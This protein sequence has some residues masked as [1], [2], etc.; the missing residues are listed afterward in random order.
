MRSVFFCQLMALSVFFCL[1]PLEAQNYDYQSNSTSGFQSDLLAHFYQQE[2]EGGEE[3]ESYSSASSADSC[4]TSGY[5]YDNVC[6]S[7]ECNNTGYHKTSNVEEID[8]EYKADDCSR[9]AKKKNAEKLFDDLNI[10]E[11]SLSDMCAGECPEGETCDPTG[12]WSVGNDNIDIEK[13]DEGCGYKVKT[14]T[15]ILDYISLKAACWCS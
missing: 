12:F 11:F 8:A 7:D 10:T 2:W 4:S 6:A 14:T 3:E 1:S 13:L 5:N 9:D 15:G